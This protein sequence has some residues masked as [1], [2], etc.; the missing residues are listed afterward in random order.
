MGVGSWRKSRDRL[1]PVDAKTI[2]LGYKEADFIANFS[3]TNAYWDLKARE[4]R[5]T[6]RNQN[7]IHSLAAILT[8]SNQR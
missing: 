4:T 6:K 3:N 5:K 2:A 8:F 1:P 7:N